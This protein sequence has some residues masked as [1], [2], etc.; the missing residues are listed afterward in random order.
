MWVKGGFPGKTSDFTIFKGYLSGTLR[1]YERVMA[2]LGYRGEEDNLLVPIYRP[3]NQEERDFN[4][5]LNVIRSKIERMNSRI[6]IFGCLT[7]VWRHD[8]ELLSQCF[9]VI[10]QITNFSSEQE[11]K[12]NKVFTLF[13]HP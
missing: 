10:C 8:T 3:W 5:H 4:I 7:S 9:H 12:K 6:K 2:D 1:H 11:H 13:H